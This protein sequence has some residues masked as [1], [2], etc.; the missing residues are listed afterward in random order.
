MKKADGKLIKLNQNNVKIK[1]SENSIS[2][3]IKNNHTVSINE[4]GLISINNIHKSESSTKMEKND[5]NDN[6]I[7]NNPSKLS[8]NNSLDNKSARSTS[9]ENKNGRS[10]DQKED[11]S[12]QIVKRLEEIYKKYETTFDQDDATDFETIL[13]TLKNN[14]F[15]E[16]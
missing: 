5:N 4:P 16:N 15:N 13:E 9:N 1:S 2:N 3:F 10:N 7:L 6:I 14:L 11:E 8:S 12:V